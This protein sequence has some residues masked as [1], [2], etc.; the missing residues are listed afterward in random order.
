MAEIIWS[1][2]AL[3]DLEAIAD[4][5]A[6]DDPQAARGLVQRVFRHVWQLSEHP[7][8]GSRVKE[9]GNSRYRQ[10][11]EPSCRIFYRCDGPRIYILHVMRG[12][13]RLR[14]TKLRERDRKRS[15]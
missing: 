13:M 14:K 8:S 15:K 6:L 9:L 3:H 11:V 5:I 10:I 7:E 1:E 2:P 4:Y 12:E